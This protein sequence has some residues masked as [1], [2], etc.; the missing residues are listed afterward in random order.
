M[1]IKMVLVSGGSKYIE[2]VYVAE[3]TYDLRQLSVFSRP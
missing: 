3:F 1:G 2:V